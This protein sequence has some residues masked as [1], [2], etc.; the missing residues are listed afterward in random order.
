M[1]LGIEFTVARV[2]AMVGMMIPFTITSTGIPGW[3][4]QRIVGYI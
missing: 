1:K 4:Y 3:M 2:T